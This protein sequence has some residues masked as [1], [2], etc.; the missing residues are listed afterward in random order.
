MFFFFPFTEMP[1]PDM[2][3][4]VSITLYHPTVIKVPILERDSCCH[5]PSFQWLSIS[6]AVQLLSW[7]A[8]VVE[9]VWAL[10]NSC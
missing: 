5:V 6:V 1:Y 9:S 2:W 8:E 7:P 3:E 10:S 4:L